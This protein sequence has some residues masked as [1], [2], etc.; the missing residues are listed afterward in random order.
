MM[1]S[2]GL[3]DICG[4]VTAGFTCSLCGRRVCRNDIT[5]RGAC[6]LCAGDSAEYDKRLV[7]KVLKEKGLDEVLGR[8]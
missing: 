7:D 5:V 1:D 6:K 3:C 4:K 2:A 8:I